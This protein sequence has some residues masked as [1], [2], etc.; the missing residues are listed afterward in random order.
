MTKI[1]AVSDIHGSEE[2]VRLLA[3]EAEKQNVDL[4]MIA[5]DFS[6]FGELANGMIGPFLAKGKKVVFVTGNHEAPGVAELLTEKYKITNIQNH[7]VV[8]D[9]VGI[10]GCGGAN[11]MGMNFL[12]D[13]E[14]FDYLDNGFRYVKGAGKKIMLTHVH[15]K[16]GL[17]ERF[18]FPGSEAVTKAIYELKP[19]IHI[20]GHIH[21][22]EGFIEKMGGT[23]IICVGSRGK[24]IEI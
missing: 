16:G 10:F 18:S 21:E 23:D 15:P 3:D 7:S 8:Y 1:L 17:I 9:D 2:T 22:M 14:I 4:V 12:T 19:D 5:G 6:E 11:I 20:C 24:I 13:A